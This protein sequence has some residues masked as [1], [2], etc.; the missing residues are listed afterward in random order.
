MKNKGR[1]RPLDVPCLLVSIEI[2]RDAVPHLGRLHGEV[3]VLN[4]YRLRRE[5]EHPGPH[6]RAEVFD[7]VPPAPL[8]AFDRTVASGA[9]EIN[10]FRFR[11]MHA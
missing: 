1:H 7:G 11:S 8:C 4:Q 9:R 10:M 6:E 2:F 5:V 3:V